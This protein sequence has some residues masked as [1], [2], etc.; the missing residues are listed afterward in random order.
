MCRS[1]LYPVLR[2]HL[3]THL[4]SPRRLSALYSVGDS[5]LDVLALLLLATA[6]DAGRIL[7]ARGASVSKRGGAEPRWRAVLGHVV[8][9]LALF[10]QLVVAVWCSTDAWPAG[11]HDDGEYHA[12]AVCLCVSIPAATVAVW[13]LGTLATRWT[14]HRSRQGE[15]RAAHALHFH[16]ARADRQGAQSGWL[17]R[18]PLPGG[19]EVTA[20]HA[21]DPARR[22][23]RGAPA[24]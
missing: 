12:G 1:V 14:Q 3:A 23:S 19:S 15:V 8:V 4:L 11:G 17:P 6:V 5:N 24:G 10:K 20:S 7:A 9:A 18:T 22:G 2:L 21:A 13:I 16:G